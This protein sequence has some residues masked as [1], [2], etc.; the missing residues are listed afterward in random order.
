M[1]LNNI[2]L[3]DKIDMSKFQRNKTEIKPKRFK[4]ILNIQENLFNDKN[5]A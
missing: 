5:E 2:T 1:L 3:L 4:I